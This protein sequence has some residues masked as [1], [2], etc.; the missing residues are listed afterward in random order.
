MTAGKGCHTWRPS[1]EEAVPLIYGT[2]NQG[3]GPLA[4]T[5]G[6]SLEKNQSNSNGLS[7]HCPLGPHPGVHVAGKPDVCF[8]SGIKTSFQSNISQ[9]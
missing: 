2:D 7:W 6:D 4:S 8:G 1:G 5:K 9:R 3:Y